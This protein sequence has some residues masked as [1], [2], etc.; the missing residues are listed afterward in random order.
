MPKPGFGVTSSWNSVVSQISSVQQI[1]ECFSVSLIEAPMLDTTRV[2]WKK[3]AGTRDLP[4][5]WANR[6]QAH[7]KQ[8]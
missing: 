2:E 3:E 6:V 7:L 8:H 1:N 5:Q 4:S